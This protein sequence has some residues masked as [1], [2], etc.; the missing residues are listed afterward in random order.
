MVAGR[1]AG[2]RTVAALW[3]PMPRADLECER[4]DHLAESFAELLTIFP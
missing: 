3:G 2:V 4:P 1:L